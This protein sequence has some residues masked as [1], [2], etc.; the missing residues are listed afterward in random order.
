[1]QERLQAGLR[2]RHPKVFLLPFR[3]FL[4]A[5]AEDQT[6]ILVVAPCRLHPY[7]PG[8]AKNGSQQADFRGYEL[9]RLNQE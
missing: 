9:L 7:Q 5:R 3:T 6:K 8:R 2:K 1:M 4:Q